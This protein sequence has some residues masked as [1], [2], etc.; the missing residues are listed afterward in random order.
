MGLI[1]KRK[2]PAVP[3]SVSTTTKEK[4]PQ[5][6]PL[7]PLSSAP[8]SEM[9]SSLSA[10]PPWPRTEDKL[11]VSSGNRD[12]S[13]PLSLGVPVAP[14]PVFPEFLD[15]VPTDLDKP[16]S[17][18]CAVK[19]ACSLPSRSGE[20][21]TENPTSTRRDT[22][23]PAHP[24]SFPRDTELWMSPNSH[25]L[26]NPS[27]STPPLDSSLPSMASVPRPILSVSASPRN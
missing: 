18:T 2:W 6:T 15:L 16:P 3:P 11:T 1:R 26:L 24:S 22:P 9:M 4:C 21:G 10:T 27:T 12:I 7:C 8:L 14:S 17:V 23:L 5:R 20:N 13:I 25:L 19:V